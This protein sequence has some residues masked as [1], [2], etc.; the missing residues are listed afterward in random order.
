MAV[1]I[2]RVS[3]LTQTQKRDDALD[4]ILPSR[5]FHVSAAGN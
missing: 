4:F 1:F 3:G 5:R 2:S